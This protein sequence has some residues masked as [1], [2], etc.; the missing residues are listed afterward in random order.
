[1]T[2]FN[3]NDFFYALVMDLA[4]A[5]W[6]CITDIM[7]GDDLKTIGD[8]KEAGICYTIICLPAFFLVLQKLVKMT[9]LGQEG[10]NF[11]WSLFLTI[12]V[13]WAH[14]LILLFWMWANPMSLRYPSILF[15]SFFLGTKIVGVF[16]HTPQMKEFSMRL[17]VL[18]TSVESPLQLLL[19]F[20]IWLAGGELY[21]GTIIS[22]VVDIAKVGVSWSWSWSHSFLTNNPR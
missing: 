6:D 18:E 4:P 9:K 5:A 17:S 1:M 20:H 11:S 10:D 3:L 12:F 2:H 13:A 8:D 7:F 21:I 19:L 16:L 22:S 15:S 14:L